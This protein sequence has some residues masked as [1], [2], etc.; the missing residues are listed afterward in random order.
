MDSQDYLEVIIT[1]SPLTE[2]TAEILE[3]QLSEIGFD[4]FM[5]EDSA[6]KCY[7]QAEDFKEE[8]L[9]EIL[10][11]FQ[12]FNPGIDLSYS[13]SHMPQQNWNAEW[14]SSGF[15]PI[16]VDS[17]VTILPK[18]RETDSTTRY[19]ISLDPNMA[20]GT[21][22]HHTT[23]MMM[24]TMLSIEESIKGHNVTDLGCGTGVL[25]ILASEMGAKSVIA[26]DI[27]AV[28]ARSA[29]ENFTYN[30]CYESSVVKCGD[31]SSLEPDIDVLLANIHRNIIINDIDHY[32]KFVNKGGFL[33]VSGFYTTDAEDIIKAA[34]MAGFRL[35]GPK[36]DSIKSQDEWACIKFI[37]E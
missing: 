26:I 23:Y 27:D 37:K 29:V 24:Q 19:T 1:V 7:I 11:D 3:A 33:L 21:G 9:K 32:S 36:T 17:D 25:G 14:E 15:T 22:H 8:D 31:A 18:G 5:T 13:F 28:A 4:A 30:G 34:D 20:F 6:L 16:I 10:E 35:A 2:D 12:G